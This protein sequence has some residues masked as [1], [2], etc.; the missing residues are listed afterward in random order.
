[1]LIPIGTDVE[2][3]R[4]PFVTYALI[5]LNLLVFAS[6]WAFH[7]SGGFEARSDVAHMFAQAIENGALSSQNFHFYSLFTYQFLHAGWMHILGNML[8]L[9]PFGK[10]VEDRLGHV[11]FALF[12]LGCGAFAGGM[13]AITSSAPV[14]GASGSVCAVTAAFIVLAP[15][16]SIKVLLIFFII[17]VYQIPSL[18]LVAF[19]VLFDLFSLLASAAGSNTDP[20]AWVAHLSG[21]LSGFIVTFLLLKASFIASRQFDLTEMLKQANRRRSY[22]RIVEGSNKNVVASTTQDDPVLLVRAQISEEVAAGKQ[23]QAADTYFR[24]REKYPKLRISSQIHAALANALLQ[25]GKIK[26]GVLLYEEYLTNFTK[27]QDCPE[28]ALLLA[29]KY[30][31][32]LHN[33][34]RALALLQKYSSLFSKKHK[35]LAATLLNELKHEHDTVS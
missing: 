3:K 13:H 31:R 16:T 14:I 28:V 1:M 23:I 27:A 4:Y 18:L 15:K 8:F 6:Q 21:Y 11:G 26:E 22:K 12:Y 2:N 10:A 17:G 5:G 9:L 24:E 34:Q 33:E 29:A 35:A 30:T 32:V 7:R 25:E 19:F 20:T